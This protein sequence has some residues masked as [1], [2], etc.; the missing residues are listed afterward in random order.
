MSGKRVTLILPATDETSTLQETVHRSI[1]LL[2]QYDLT[3]YIIT[4]P[5]LTTT[6][7]REAI[8]H[9][10]SELGEKILTFDQKRGG[11]G[12]A[13]REGFER[14]D[15]DITVL[16]SSDMETDPVALP[17]LL[18]KIAEGYDIAAA[19]RW[20][21]TGSFSGYG[22]LKLVL[23]FI[24]QQLF[25][26][27]YWTD[28]SDLTYAFRAYRTDIVKKIR[29]E[30]AGFPFLFESLVKPLRLGYRIAEVPAPWKARTEGA[31]HNG[32][33]Q[34]LDYIRVGVRTRYLPL[35]RIRY[36]SPL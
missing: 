24:F 19:T 9:L 29:W 12:C 35:E 31:S 33:R 2:P 25:R 8:R 5:K 4:S 21:D 32:L 6:A 30:E 20:R 10:Q 11:L 3:C 1:R 26:L 15:G 7:C 28:L 36:T 23:N 22:P 34:T 18:Q 13:V 17:A 27:L 14:A 16:M